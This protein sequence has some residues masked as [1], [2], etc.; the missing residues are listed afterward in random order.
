MKRKLFLMVALCCL[1]GIQGVIAQS[2]KVLYVETASKT[3]IDS[4]LPVLQR[5]FTV[6]TTTD[7]TG[8]TQDYT[9]A[10]VV[11]ISEYPGSG[12]INALKN[13]SKPVFVMKAHQLAN[14][15]RWAWATGTVLQD[16]TALSINVAEPDR[17]NDLYKGLVLENGAY[18][19]L[20]AVD[21]SKGLM[22][23]TGF[24]V[25]GDAR[26]YLGENADSTV[27]SIFNAGVQADGT[28][29][30]NAKYIYFG[31][32]SNSFQY[33]TANARQLIVNGVK[34]LGGQVPTGTEE[35][36]AKI[37]YV[38]DNISRLA[39]DPLYNSL[40]A[41]G[42]EFI[43]VQAVAKGD[44]PD[45]AGMDVVLISEYAGG[46]NIKAFEN[47]SIPVF[48]MKGHTLQ[49]N[50]DRWNWVTANSTYQSNVETELYMSVASTAGPLFAN[51]TT[52]PD[53]SIKLLSQVGGGKGLIGIKDIPAISGAQASNIGEITGATNTSDTMMFYLAAGATV[54]D[55]ATPYVLNSDYFYI[56]VTGA[57]SLP[58]ATK[59]FVQIAA[60]AIAMLTNTTAKQIQDVTIAVE[61]ATGGSVSG[62]ESSYFAG[63]NYSITATPDADFILEK[64]EVKNGDVW[65]E[66]STSATIDGVATASLNLRPVFVAAQ[67]N[68]IDLKVV[69]IA[70]NAANAAD[71]IFQVLNRNFTNA[72]AK[73]IS[74]AVSA[75]DSTELVTNYDVIV[76]SPF[77][78]NDNGMRLKNISKPVLVMNA[79]MILRHQSNNPQTRWEWGYYN[80]STQESFAYEAAMLN[81]QSLVVSASAKSH[82]LYSGLAFIGNSLNL[83]DS[84]YISNTS[85]NVGFMA[86]RLK[87]EAQAQALATVE[88]APSSGNNAVI[89]F[90]PQGTMADGQNALNSNYCFIGINNGLA[91]AQQYRLNNNAKQLVVNAVQAL[92][93]LNPAGTEEMKGVVA[94]SVTSVTVS[95]PTLSMRVPSI[96]KL[97]AAVVSSA[98]ADDVVRWTSSNESVATVDF[99]GNVQAV[100]TGTANIIATVADGS[101]SGTCAVTVEANAPEV[102]L[103]EYFSDWAFRSSAMPIA[104]TDS[105][106][107]YGK[108]IINDV[109][110]VRPLKGSAVG[111]NVTISLYN[112]IVFPYFGSKFGN[113]YPGFLMT[114][115]PNGNYSPSRT[116]NVTTSPNPPIYPEQGSNGIINMSQSGY[117]TIGQVDKDVKT[118]E[119]VLSVDGENRGGNVQK[120]YDRRTWYS[121]DAVV[122][123]DDM[124]RLDGFKMDNSRA[125]KFIIHLPKA[126]K[127]F[128]LRIGPG[129][130][131]VDGQP[132][133]NRYLRIHNVRYFGTSSTNVPITALQITA[134][135]GTNGD[136]SNG[137]P[138][139]TTAPGSWCDASGVLKLSSV[140]TPLDATNASVTWVSSNPSVASVDATGNVSPLDN[141]TVEITA[142]AADGSG[143]STKVW[144]S[145][146][147]NASATICP[148]SVVVNKIWTTRYL[149]IP[150]EEPYQLTHTLYP[151]GATQKVV[152]KSL[153]EFIEVLDETE[154]YIQGVNKGWGLIEVSVET[155]NE[156]GRR[157]ADTLDVRVLAPIY[158]GGEPT[159]DPGAPKLPVLF[160]A[161]EKL[162]PPVLGA[163]GNLDED[164]AENVWLNFSVTGLRGV[165]DSTGVNKFASNDDD[166]GIYNYS[167][168]QG[169]YIDKIEPLTP[170]GFVNIGLKTTKAA[171]AG[172][173]GGHRLIFAFDGELDSL[174][175]GVVVTGETFPSTVAIQESN[176]ATSWSDIYYI[177][178]NASAT[179]ETE[180]ASM[181]TLLTPNVYTYP[182]ITGFNKNSRFVRLV[183]TESGT[184]SAVAHNIYFDGIWLYGDNDDDGGETGVKADVADHGM[185]V[186]PNPVNDM[187]YISGEKEIAKVEIVNLQ[188]GSKVYSSSSLRGTSSQVS[189][190]NLAGGTYLVVV[191]V[192]GSD[193]PQVVK[194][195]KQ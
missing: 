178:N 99:R 101:V 166:E 79:G 8:A 27:V 108:A 107:N 56:G 141:G 187:L 86:T 147:K 122:E 41:A 43:R 5:N 135:A 92:A 62:V 82:A 84:I 192:Y 9:D 50:A 171:G 186:Y 126:E 131:R 94:P 134:P 103:D 173:K 179:K 105:H 17:S 153:S 125:N 148:D 38:L 67:D 149:E 132:M 11:F 151:A 181:Y 140:C 152:Y 158:L 155:N 120:S 110:I 89:A 12:N 161:R 36:P 124:G 184:S 10:D 193:K 91:A 146:T 164:W 54:G 189:V 104:P 157:I 97:T 24:K 61:A 32:T 191:Y 136:G 182:V 117:V 16:P 60:N 156:V 144:V 115:G 112:T 72:T 170:Q 90:M 95:Q 109:D 143:V 1:M 30:L 58:Y 37:L 116:A 183:Q 80:Q 23:V 121:V 13:L 21:V 188:T 70:N 7:L 14:A 73:I 172:S 114:T 159:P 168:I 176:D 111:T 76:L 51:V 177:V 48:T 28:E 15:S 169:V 185:V 195:N 35:I 25:A 64:W 83:F 40:K 138:Y 93:G 133:G 154:G 85:R 96:V 55:G 39:T 77:I 167:R 46:S 78:T 69:Y 4:V 119:L 190:N 59:N 128:Y 53:G 180:S 49:I 123:N 129:G 44:V 175:I 162:S 165:V 29:G 3:T 100:G 47:L 2:L 130:D 163:T 31:L 68:R 75:D 19:L 66:L 88:P 74:S 150:A 57:E 22:P 174:K 137:S 113:D 71:T 65:E 102:I 81:Q 139:T 33:M 87:A 63:Q 18:Q 118:I 45:T 34:I 142:T 6:T 194:I 160:D 52:E 42:Y 106:P 26:G 98:L 127:N 145:V 20:T